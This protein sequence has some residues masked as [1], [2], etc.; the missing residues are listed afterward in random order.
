VRCRDVLLW[1]DHAAELTRVPPGD[2]LQLTGREL[3]RVAAHTALCAAVGQPEERALPRHPDGERG[4]L[5]ERDVRVVADP[6]LRGAEDARRLAAVRGKDADVAG[7][8]PDR[9]GDHDRPF[10]IAQALDDRLV[11]FRIRDRLLE[12]PLCR[13]KEWRVPLELHVVGGQLLWLCHGRSVGWWRAGGGTR[14]RA[15]PRGAD[16]LQSS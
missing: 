4:T 11:D 13:T 12:L 3:A 16:G 15:P 9:D 2:P 6:P 8:A 14:T 7:V 10:R 1:A 5:T